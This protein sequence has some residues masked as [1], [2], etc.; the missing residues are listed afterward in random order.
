MGELK[1]RAKP[2][3]DARLHIVARDEPLQVTGDGEPG[4]RGGEVDSRQSGEGERDPHAGAGELGL[5]RVA[6][7]AAGG[8]GGST[9]ATLGIGDEVPFTT[10]LWKLRVAIGEELRGDVLGGA[11]RASIARGNVWC[12]TWD[13]RCTC[14]EAF[15]WAGNDTARTAL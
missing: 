2:L 8:N 13:V 6:A 10:G 11:I 3:G 4:P 15:A 12:T 9:D 7:A 14:D 1:W 5:H